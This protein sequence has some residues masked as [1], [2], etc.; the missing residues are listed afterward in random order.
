[1]PLLDD[2]FADLDREW[3]LPGE[4][5]IP[6]HII[7]SAALMLQTNYERGTKDADV[8]ELQELSAP[9]VAEL[10]RLAG[11]KTRIHQRHRIYLDI[12]AGGLPFLP[13]K[14]T[15]HPCNPAT[16]LSTFELHILDVVD[17]VVSKLK[18][19][20]ADDRGDIDAMIKR[21]AVAHDALLERFNKAVDWCRG[22]ARAEHLPRYVRNLNQVERDML[23]VSETAFDL[24]DVHY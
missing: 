12:V 4:T 2:F 17:V 24:D 14:P 3:G 19:F 20:N 23:I 1:M 10:K 15:W 22:D 18:R 6:L 16:P 9:I 5:T 7:G 11:P 21:G 13:Q 8:L